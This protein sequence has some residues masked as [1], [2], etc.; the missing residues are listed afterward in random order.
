MKKTLKDISYYQ[1]L[2]YTITLRKDE[3]GDYVARIQELSGCIAHGETEAE[4]IMDLRSMQALWLEDAI[5]SGDKIPE[6][7]QDDL[8]SGKW[9]QR[10]PR[11]LHRD[12]QQHAAKENISLNQLVTSMLSEALTSRS[13]V[14]VMENFLRIKAANVAVVY[15]RQHF[16]EWTTMERGMGAGGWMTQWSRGVPMLMKEDALVKNM[17]GSP[18]LFF[19]PR[20]YAAE[21]EEIT[22]QQ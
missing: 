16:G 9:V 4:A 11:R 22:C 15:P 20:E 21:D 1:G 18:S 6:P 3:E 12:L 17:L 19:A 2:P 7:E 5:A 13:C 8:P 14:Q 10:V